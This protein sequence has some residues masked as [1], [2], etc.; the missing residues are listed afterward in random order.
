MF[1]SQWSL[2]G[3][4]GMASTEDKMEV[5]RD[6]GLVEWLK[7]EMLSGV[8]SFYQLMHRDGRENQEAV[9]DVIANIILVAYLLARRLGMTYTAIDLKIQNKIK[10]GITE[11]HEVEKRYKDLSEL[12]GY[13]NRN[14]RQV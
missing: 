1:S 12:A 7:C 6:M 9:S 3:E 13:L 14:R 10:L 11:D 4:Q 2:R 5:I 8:A